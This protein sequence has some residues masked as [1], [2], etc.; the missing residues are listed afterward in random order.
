MKI[1]SVLCAAIL[2]LASLALSQDTYHPVASRNSTSTQAPQ[3]SDNMTAAENTGGGDAG[4]LPQTA[5]PF[6][7]Y[8][9]L[10]AGFLLAGY[11]TLKSERRSN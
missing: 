6:P 11:M 5:N 3:S 8:G 9:F 10:S 4:T 2:G 1:L 7:L